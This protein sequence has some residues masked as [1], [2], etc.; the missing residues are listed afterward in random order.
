MLGKN[1][2][3]TMTQKGFTLVETLIYLSLIGVT[4]TSFISFNLTISSARNKNTAISE[5]QSNALT[6]LNFMSTKLR[7]AKKIILPIA[8]ESSYSLI[9]RQSDNGVDLRIYLNS[10]NGILYY[11]EGAG[12]EIPITS[13]KVLINNLVFSN[14][15]S[16][17]DPGNIGINLG[18]QYNNPSNSME[19]AYFQ[20]YQTDIN[21]RLK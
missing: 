20:D 14:L 6:A 9:F 19:F 3:K 15:T 21:L 8:G 11:S 18:L 16:G 10:E 12:T 17:Q 4:I 2:N 7:S 5:V 13:S 1:I